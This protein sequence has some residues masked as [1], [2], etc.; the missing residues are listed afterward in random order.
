MVGNVGEGGEDERV[1]GA[2]RSA[3]IGDVGL[4]CRIVAFV[5]GLRVDHQAVRAV[6]NRFRSKARLA[7]GARAVHVLPRAHLQAAGVE[8]GDELG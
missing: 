6:R 1:G 2:D 7:G 8:F 3:Q 5:L 4:R